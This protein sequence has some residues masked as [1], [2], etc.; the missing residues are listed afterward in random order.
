MRSGF[1]CVLLE[2]CCVSRSPLF[3]REAELLMP[4]GFLLPVLR[5][6]SLAAVE[7][8]VAAGAGAQS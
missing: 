2:G 4:G 5:L 3:G 7:D 1:G 8:D 6:E